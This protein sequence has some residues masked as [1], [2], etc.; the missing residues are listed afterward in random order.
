MSITHFSSYGQQFDDGKVGEMGGSKEQMFTSIINMEELL[1]YVHEKAFEFSLE[2]PVNAE[3][4]QKICLK[5]RNEFQQSKNGLFRKC[6]EQVSIK[7][8]TNFQL[9]E[10]NIKSILMDEDLTKK[11]QTFKVAVT[12]YFA[13][14]KF[15]GA[16]AVFIKY[17][18]DT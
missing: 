7:L 9:G 14:K 6:C 3:Q 18:I 17:L 11:S 12:R 1:K 5:I 10:E 16:V 15:F 13:D 4:A 2:N 8:Q